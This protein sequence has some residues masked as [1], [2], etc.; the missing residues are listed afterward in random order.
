MRL[1]AA[2]DGGTGACGAECGG[3]VWMPLPD[4]VFLTECVAVVQA[5]GPA[6]RGIHAAPRLKWPFM[7]IFPSLSDI[8]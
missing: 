5:V 4:G 7:A 6:S 8:L 3:V 2:D 1:S